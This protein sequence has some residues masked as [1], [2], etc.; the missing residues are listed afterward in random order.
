MLPASCHVITEATLGFCQ[1]GG[2]DKSSPQINSFISLICLA[3]CRFT[4]FVCNHFNS[5]LWQLYTFR[6]S[7][8]LKVCL[9]PT[10]RMWDCAKSS[11]LI[12][13]R[14]LSLAALLMSRFPSPASSIRSP[15]FL[16]WVPGF[17][18]APLPTADD[19]DACDSWIMILKQW[20]EKSSTRSPWVEMGLFLNMLTNTW[21]KKIHRLKCS[22]VTSLGPQHC[23]FPGFTTLISF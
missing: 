5:P 20:V 17:V 2:H 14:N 6:S 3:P 21:T 12:A 13:Q 10:G 18:R 16:A 7:L 15:A 1:Q 4:M 8:F 22:H 23:H 11:Q 19:S 9:N